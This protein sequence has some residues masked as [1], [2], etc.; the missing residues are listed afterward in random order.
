M[1]SARP[2][3]AWRGHSKVRVRREGPIPEDK[4]ARY[5]RLPEGE[6]NHRH[7]Q[8]QMQGRRS[9]GRGALFWRLGA[10]SKACARAYR[11]LL[12]VAGAQRTRYRGEEVTRPDREELAAVH[13]DYPG[14]VDEA[15]HER[16][17]VGR[18]GD[19]HAVVQIVFDHGVYEDREVGNPVPLHG[20]AAGR[21]VA[22]G[23]VV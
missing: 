10:G 8:P 3:G 22:A 12:V 1:P 18:T 4:M 19:L 7:H 2:E 17:F 14:W 5:K 13:G 6:D 21:A 16:A 15:G 9:H 11:R 23:A 20:H